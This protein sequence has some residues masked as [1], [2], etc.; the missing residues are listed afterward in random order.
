MRHLAV[1][2]TLAG[3][4]GSSGPYCVGGEPVTI[5]QGVYGYTFGT[6]SD[7]ISPD[8]SVPVFDG[9]G[10]IK[11][12]FESDDSGAYQKALPSGD[13]WLCDDQ[14]MHCRTIYI[15]AGTIYHADHYDDSGSAHWVLGGGLGCKGSAAN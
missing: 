15:S 1:L 13:Y 7:D 14:F 4:T 5:G 12:Q 6:G 8:E 2:V 3:C 11:T 9:A 10:G